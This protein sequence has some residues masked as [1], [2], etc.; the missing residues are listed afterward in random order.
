MKKGDLIRYWDTFMSEHRMGIVTSKRMYMGRL[1]IRFIN[2][3]TG[4]H[5]EIHEDFMRA[6]VVSEGR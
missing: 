5:S 4:R 1:Y 3:D 2:L 6:E